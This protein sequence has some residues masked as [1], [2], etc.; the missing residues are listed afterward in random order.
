MGAPPVYFRII[1]SPFKI[2]T[3]IISAESLFLYKITYAQ[4]PGI[5][6]WAYLGPSFCWPYLGTRKSVPGWWEIPLATAS[7]SC[8]GAPVGEM[9]KSAFYCQLVLL[10]SI[11][12][13]LLLPSK[14][15]KEV[16]L[17]PIYMKQSFLVTW[18]WDLRG[19]CVDTSCHSLGSE[20]LGQEMFLCFMRWCWPFHPGSIRP[21][22]NLCLATPPSWGP[23]RFFPAIWS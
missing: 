20:G 23:L 5:R 1:I 9:T 6:T 7:W 21:C 14:Q 4:V 3:L 22:T 12:H 15:Q 8:G 17:L 10:V 2:L 18:L 16:L 11:C 19:Q 13:H